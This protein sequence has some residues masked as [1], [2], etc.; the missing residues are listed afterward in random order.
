MPFSNTVWSTSCNENWTKIYLIIMIWEKINVTSMFSCIDAKRIIAAK[1]NNKSHINHIMQC[2]TYTLGVP[3][4][5][6]YCYKCVV[7]LFQCQSSFLWLF[8]WVRDWIFVNINLQLKQICDK[9]SFPAHVSFATVPFCKLQLIQCNN[10]G[11][12]SKRYM[13]LISKSNQGNYFL[14]TPPITLD[15]N[16][17]NKAIF[18]NDYNIT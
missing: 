3:H 17:N 5:F 6:L 10:I 2:H 7:F 16:E 11:C 18:L 14:S 1:S 9:C 15:N 13:G 12:S 4:S 8:P